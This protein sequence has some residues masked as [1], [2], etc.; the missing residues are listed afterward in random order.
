[1]TTE[2]ADIIAACDLADARTAAMPEPPHPRFTDKQ[3]QIL[4]H[5]AR[6]NDRAR[7]AREVG[8]A[9]VTLDDYLRRLRGRLGA[10]STT[11]LITLAIA[12]GIIPGD[13]AKGSELPRW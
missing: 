6:G 5:L 1:M 2:D 13:V 10:R 4:T 12:A 9:V 3:V 8:L 7:T 11:H